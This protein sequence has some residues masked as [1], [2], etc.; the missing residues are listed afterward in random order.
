MRFGRF[1]SGGI[2]PLGSG[3][4]KKTFTNPK[5]PD[6]VIQVIKDIEGTEKQSIRKLKGTYYLTKIAHIL[7]PHRVPDI[8][9]ARES[10]EGQQS[11][12]RERIA[13]TAGHELLQK[14]LE[15]DE[16]TTVGI[17]RMLEEIGSDITTA[18][19]E[20]ED[21]GL[22]LIDDKNILNYTRGADGSVYYLESFQ[23]WDDYGRVPELLFDIDILREAIEKLPDEK[24]RK[25]CESRLERLLKLF[26]EEK[27]DFLERSQP[28]EAVRERE[29]QEITEAIGELDALFNAFVTKHNLDALYAIQTEAEAYE[30]EVRKSAIKERGILLTHLQSIQSLKITDEQRLALQQIYNVIFNAIGAINRGR[31]DHHR[32]S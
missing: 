18:T 26:E 1:E 11:F 15:T 27:R 7:L 8:Y 6:R 29:S 2:P 25:I 28:S 13:L 32:L 16:D 23:P 30:S 21:I 9:Q 31:V 3:D 19:H 4:E 17:E 24:S 12:D 10:T 20:L 5:N 22:D 14:Q